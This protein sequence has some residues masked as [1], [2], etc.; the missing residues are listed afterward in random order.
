MSPKDY[1]FLFKLAFSIEKK[2]KFRQKKKL[3]SRRRKNE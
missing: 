3:F 2:V 1:T